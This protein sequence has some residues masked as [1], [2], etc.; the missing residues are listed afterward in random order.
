MGDAL[1]VGIVTQSSLLLACLV[2]YRVTLSDRAIGSLAGLGSGALL[3]AASFQLV[4]QA[5]ASLGNLEIGL[6]LV[7]G[8]AV[9][10][11]AD[12]LVERRFGESG[13]M[14]IVVGNIIDALPESLIFGIQLAA[15]LAVSP[16]LAASV[17]VSNIPQA[18]APA[19][20]MRASGWPALKQVTL[21]GSV[22]VVAG[23]CA[24][25]GFAAADAIRDVD[26]ARLAAFTTGA[27]VTMLTTS[28]IPFAYRKAHV[29]AGMWAVVGFGLTLAGS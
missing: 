8:G 2:V 23:V 29:A 3:G 26:G 13:A 18:L 7:A 5:L 24:A 12:R 4:P 20:D 17:W 15:G 22:V 6:W 10:V 11:V 28:M 14:G 19:A 1:I 25:L 21:W 27:L 9:Y 16:A